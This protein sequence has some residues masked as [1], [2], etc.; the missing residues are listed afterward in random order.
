[1][2]RGDPDGLAYVIYTSGSTGKPKGVMVTHRG[3]VNRLL[4]MQETYRLTPDERILQ[5]T[6]FGFDV[7]VW[8]FLWPLLAGA[9]LVLA[10][11]GSHQDPAQTAGLVARERITTIHFVPAM[12]RLFLDDADPV[13]CV[14]L[15]RVVC[16][17]EALPPD[18][19]R[20]CREALPTA[21]VHNLYG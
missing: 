4:W 20:R 3:L 19:V 13:R 21:E 10:P 12:L 5:K 8:E 1:E 17:G 18:L 9:R 6:P 7:S 15:A 14:S 11:P 16:S 2:R